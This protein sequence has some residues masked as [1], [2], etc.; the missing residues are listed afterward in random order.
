MPY[1]IVQTGWETDGIGPLCVGTLRRAGVWRRVFPALW[2]LISMGATLTSARRTPCLALA[3]GLLFDPRASC[4]VWGGD[5]L[6]KTVSGVNTYKV[7]DVYIDRLKADSIE[8]RGVLS[9]GVPL[10]IVL[11]FETN[12][13]SWPLMLCGGVWALEI[14]WSIQFRGQI[15]SGEV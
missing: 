3:P 2:S 13:E 6:I 15:I 12:K 11:L 10:W 4:F 9:R 14:V 8:T 7:N 1:C 5:N